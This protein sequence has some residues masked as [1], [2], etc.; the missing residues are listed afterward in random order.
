MNEPEIEELKKLLKSAM[1]PVTE[2]EFQRDLWPQVRRR[3]EQ[4]AF[5][6]PW[7]DW[8]LLAGVTAIFC[9]FP[10]LIPALLYHL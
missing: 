9:F 7:W 2:T 8:T 1:P 10:G 3:L 6:L 4:R 5:D